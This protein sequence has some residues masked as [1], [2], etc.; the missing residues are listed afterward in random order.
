MTRATLILGSTVAATACALACLATTA[1]A[2]VP[3]CTR[4]GATLLAA[5]GATRVISVR[6]RARN[7][8]T[9]RDYVMGCRTPTG[10][11]FGLFLRRDFGLDLIERDA[12]TVVDGR[13]IGVLRDFEGGV[14]ES[15]SAAVWDSWTRTRLHDS[16][17]CDEVDSGDFSGVEDVAFLPRGGMAYACQGLRIADA[18]GDRELEPAGTD[19]RNVVV[20]IPSRG[21][22]PRLYWVVVNGAAE[23]VKSL[24]I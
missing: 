24:A 10:R 8:E 15:Q 18:R 1:Q 6:V 13:Y 2:R 12:F 22:A 14:S 9:R 16:K 17:R 23:Q 4:G 7:Q 5:D 3:S 21:V 19:V 11:R 20:S